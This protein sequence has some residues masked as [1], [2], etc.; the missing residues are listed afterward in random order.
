MA[1]VD[2]PVRRRRHLLDAARRLVQD[3]GRPA[4]DLR[5]GQEPDDGAHEPRAASGCLVAAPA[6]GHEPRGV[7]RGGRESLA[8]RRRPGA[9][10]LPHDGA[11]P[12]RRA[13]LRGLVRAPA[14]EDQGWFQHQAAARRHD[15]CAGGVRLRP[16][17]LGLKRALLLMLLAAY[18]AA[19]A[20]SYPAKP[21]TLVAPSTP[22]SAPHFPPPVTPPTPP[23]HPTPPS[24]LANLP[25]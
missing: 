6:V 1:G 15:Q 21:V 4:G 16:A 11:A 14:Q 20:Q 13:P 2:R 7:Q 10:A 23:H 25:D 12:R 22:G 18:A 17:G 24:L 3:L 19:W 5:R 9:L 8:Q